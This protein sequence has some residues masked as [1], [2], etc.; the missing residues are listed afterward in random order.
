M[1][2]EQ[3]IWAQAKAAEIACGR[4]SPRSL[5]ALRESLEETCT[6]PAD[7]RWDRKAA[8]HAAFFGV[9]AQAADDPVVAPVLVSG[10]ELAYDLMITAGPTAN[11]IVINSRRRFLGC[12]RGG[13]A[14]GAALELQE[15][16]RILHLM[17]RL[18]GRW[19]GA[20]G[21]RPPIR[22]RALIRSTDA[23]GT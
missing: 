10:G 13:D 21:E 16:L 4:L 14:E 15:H 11:Q 20:R 5:E 17:C 12:L 1:M 6:L 8:A 18:S 7:T 2:Y 22:D 9:L 19:H 23:Q 3:L